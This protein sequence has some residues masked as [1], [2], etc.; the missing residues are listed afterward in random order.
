MRVELH[1]V[2]PRPRNAAALAGPLLTAGSTSGPA[3]TGASE[4]V[5]YGGWKPFVETYSDTFLMRLEALP[6]LPA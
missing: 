2:P 6:M 1:G 4:F 3:G 5:L